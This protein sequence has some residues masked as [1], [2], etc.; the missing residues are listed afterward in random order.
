[1]KVD[2]IYFHHSGGTAVNYYASSRNLTLQ[3]IDNVHQQRWPDFPSS[4]IN[5]KTKQGYFVGYNGVIFPDG[6]FVQTRAF[7]EETA[8]VKGYNLGSLSFCIIGNFDLGKTG[9]PIDIVTN[10]QIATMKKIMLDLLESGWKTPP[11]IIAPDTIFSIK[12]NQIYPHRFHGQ[13]DCYGTSLSDRW[14]K[15]LYLSVVG[16]KLTAIQTALFNLLQ[17][18]SKMRGIFGKFSRL[19]GVPRSCMFSGD[20]RG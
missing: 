18:V 10:Q 7:G 8:A 6:S 5:P 17:L 11:Y 16:E 3:E 2:T 20:N 4:I 19:G 12:I 1:M 14:A 13:T 9:W 15:D